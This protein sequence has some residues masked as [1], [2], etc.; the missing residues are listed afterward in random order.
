MARQPIDERVKGNQK[1]LWQASFEVPGERV[2][3]KQSWAIAM[4]ASDEQIDDYLD[5]ADTRE[6]GAP[7]YLTKDGASE[8]ISS[9]KWHKSKPKGE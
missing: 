3:W 5:E 4:N 2:T 6:D 1:R 8:L 9:G 7:G